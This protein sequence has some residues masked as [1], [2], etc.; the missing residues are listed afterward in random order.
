MYFLSLHQC[1]HVCLWVCMRAS[2]SNIC[3][4]LLCIR[5]CLFMCPR[6]HM[7]VCLDGRNYMYLFRIQL[8]SGP[9]FPLWIWYQLGDLKSYKIQWHID[10]NIFV[11]PYHTLTPGIY[12][13][14]HIKC[15][16]MQYIL[17]IMYTRMVFISTNTIYERTLYK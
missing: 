12:F 1:L 16:I 10:T 14:C 13:N 3:A 9:I 11:F 8:G 5:L 6:T 4:D 2:E 17:T 7:Y 15:N